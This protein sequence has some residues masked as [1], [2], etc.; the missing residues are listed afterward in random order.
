MIVMEAAG[1]VMPAEEVLLRARIN[2]EVATLHPEFIEGGIVRKDEILLTLDPQDYELA[3]AQAK[4][5]LE[6]ARLALA[7][8]QGQQD[9]ARREWELL[10]IERSATDEEKTLALRKPHLQ[11]REAALEAAEA[12]YKKAEVNLERT[13][14]KA[15]FNAVVTARRANIG[16]QASIQDILGGIAGTDSFWIK[17]SVP[18]DRI[19]L[20]QVPGSKV[21]AVSAGGATHEGTVIRRMAQLSQGGRMVQVLI[22]IDDPL[23]L[24]P[25][26]KGLQPLLL[27]EYVRLSI[28]GEKVQQVFRIPRK[29]LREGNT[30]WV[31]TAGNTL[32]IRKVNV[33]WRGSDSLL[34]D[35]PIKDG[36]RLIVSSLNA[37]IEGIELLVGPAQTG[38][39]INE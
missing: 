18:L 4:S 34:V 8:E 32:S 12:A 11:A 23:C 3:L 17:A 1:T 7:L 24:S 28:Q 31:A 21:T 15:P 33:R 36:D 6:Q 20:L 16:S 38:T 2:S 26:K 10:D 35:G 39:N 30:I 5:S 22:E 13:R 29:A 9:I 19:A 25:Q 14:I 27:G 37:P